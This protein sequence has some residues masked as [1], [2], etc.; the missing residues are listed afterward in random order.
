MDSPKRTLFINVLN[1]L[2]PTKD[3]SEAE[4]VY[5]TL[6]DMIENKGEMFSEFIYPVFFGEIRYL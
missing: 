2:P 5:K 6:F 4:S 3:F 1:N